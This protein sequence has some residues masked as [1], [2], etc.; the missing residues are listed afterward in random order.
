MKRLALLAAGLLVVAFLAPTVYF[1]RGLYQ[2]PPAPS[3]AWGKLISPSTPAP[4]SESTPQTRAG[5]LLLDLAH[6]NSFSLE[7]VAPLLERLLVRG[8]TIDYLKVER[9]EE[10]DEKLEEGLRRADALAVILPRQAFTPPQV[11][12]VVKFVGKGGKVLLVSDP[13]RTVDLDALASPFGLVFQKDY[14]YNLKENDGNFRNIYVRDFASH[15]ITQGLGRIALYATSSISPSTLGLARTS[16]DSQSSLL[17]GPGP[18]SPL[19][20]SGRVLGIGDLTFMME[21]YNSIGDNNRL[22]SNIA[23]WLTTSQ[24]SF[25]LEDFPHFLRGPVT[26]GLGREEALEAGLKMRGLLQA[27][28]KDSRVQSYSS[29]DSLF[30]G[31]LLDAGAIKEALQAA[32]ITVETKDK[33]VLSLKVAGLGD[34]YKEGTSLLYLPEKGNPALIILSDTPENLKEVVAELESGAFRQG[35]VSDRLAIHR[36]KP[37]EKPKEPEK[38]EPEKKTP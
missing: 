36:G 24:R 29:G 34:V 9:K 2:P 32:K 10:V 23:D 38:T 11:E 18:Y 17:S 19:A 14:L 16:P 20:L 21:P 7:E 37:P 31:L 25:L 15:P 4:Y 33:T 35:Q 22:V 27:L 1:Y 13:T 12:L 28:G 8:Y 26:V 3:P 30:L 5:T 6:D